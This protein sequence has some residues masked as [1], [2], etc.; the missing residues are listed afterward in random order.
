MKLTTQK[1]RMLIARQFDNLYELSVGRNTAKY[2]SRLLQ[3]RPKFRVEL[4]TMT[5][6]FANFITAINLS[7]QRVVGKIARPGA[8]TH[9]ATQLFNID[10]IAQLKDNRVR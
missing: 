4:V 10:Q 2:Q 1:P 8:Q 7:G 9:R 5:V 3:T 6:T